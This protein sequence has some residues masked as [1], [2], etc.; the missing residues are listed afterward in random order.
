MEKGE[1]RKEIN[2]EKKNDPSPDGTSV[3]LASRANWRAVAGP[4]GLASTAHL[5]NDERCCCSWPYCSSSP[6]TVRTVRRCSQD[7]TFPLPALR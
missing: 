3:S 7:G 5:G 1:I 6:A 4:I 2:K